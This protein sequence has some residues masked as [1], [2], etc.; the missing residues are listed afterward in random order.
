MKPSTA[1]S[2]I[3]SSK[4]HIYFMFGLGFVALAVNTATHWT[5]PAYSEYRKLVKQVRE[6]NKHLRDLI[7]RDFLDEYCNRVSPQLLPVSSSEKSALSLDSATNG[8]DLIRREIPFTTF[9][10]DNRFGFEFEGWIYQVGDTLFGERI[11]E[12]RP[13]IITTDFGV[14]VKSK[15]GGAI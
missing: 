8:C 14:F 6:E 3:M 12:I 4:T 11:I 9:R 5:H 13:E 10:S 1:L 15:K 7:L 2:A